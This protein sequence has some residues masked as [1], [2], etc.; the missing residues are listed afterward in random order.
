MAPSAQLL[1]YQILPSSEVAADSL[2]FDV[3]GEYPQEV[4][5]SFNVEEAKPGDTVT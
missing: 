3:A 4:T 1:V 5:A 2:P